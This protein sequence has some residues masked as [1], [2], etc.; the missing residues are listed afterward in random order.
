MRKRLRLQV[1]SLLWIVLALLGMA[2]RQRQT[3]EGRNKARVD[4]DLAESLHKGMPRSEVEM[5][6]QQLGF[7]N[8][9][10]DQ[11]SGALTALIQ[12]DDALQLDSVAASLVIRA[13]FDSSD[14]LTSFS[15]EVR[16]T[17]T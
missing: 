9:T 1:L 12:E 5:K 16:L 6:L 2:C 17:G 7:E 13:L 11:G 3:F 15:T 4:L 8:P 14:I 10:Y